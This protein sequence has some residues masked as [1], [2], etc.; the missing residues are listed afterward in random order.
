MASVR[1]TGP[2]KTSPGPSLIRPRLRCRARRPRLNIPDKPRPIQPP[3]VFEQSHILSKGRSL[4]PK[5]LLPMPPDQ[6]LLQIRWVRVQDRPTHLD[7]PIT[8]PCRMG[9]STII[10]L[11]LSADNYNTAQYNII[12][13]IVKDLSLSASLVYTHTTY[14]HHL[15]LLTTN[16]NSQSVRQ[17]VL[18]YDQD[19]HVHDHDHEPPPLT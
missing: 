8:N 16:A 17:S 1:W 10:L 12:Q 6:P 7:I 11:L 9:S 4:H 18:L 15:H 19:V 13:Y 14:L 2:R 5:S 3:R